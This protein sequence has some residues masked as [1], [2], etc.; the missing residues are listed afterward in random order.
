VIMAFVACSVPVTGTDTSTG[1]TTSTSTSSST[2]IDGTIKPG[3]TTVVGSVHGIVLDPAGKPVVG[4]TFAY[5]TENVVVDTSKELRSS[6]TDANGMFEI[7][8]ICSGY[9]QSIR[10]VHVPTLGELR[11]MIQ[12]GTAL[13][14]NG[15]PIGDAT[16]DLGGNPRVSVALDPLG[17]KVDG[18]ATP[19]VVTL[20]PLSA[21]VATTAYYSSSAQ[22]QGAATALPSGTKIVFDFQLA[23]I[24]PNFFE[25]TAGVGGSVNVSGLPAGD[26]EGYTIL[27]F[28]PAGVAVAQMTNGLASGSNAGV[29]PASL[30]FTLSEAPWIYSVS[31]DIS[32]DSTAV[33]LEQTF[34]PG[35]PSAPTPFVITFSRAMNKASGILA[36]SSNDMA[37]IPAIWEFDFTSSWNTAGT[38]LTVTPATRLNDGV[39]I[40]LVLT[41]FLSA[42]GLPLVG[43]TDGNE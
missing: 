17:T 3:I 18:G 22:Y 27:A 39:E 37:E 26:V 1:T 12:L 40:E 24:M 20:Y 42:D 23:G 36:L 11:D 25:S 19:N 6:V 43:G 16:L 30:Y 35:T 31:P 7:E 32:S 10:S 13:D 21:T 9:S 29:F 2:T 34:D 14:G 15:N 41:G 38:V 8:G 4:A 33:W 5:A 28:L